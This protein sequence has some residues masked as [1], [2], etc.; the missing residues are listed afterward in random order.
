MVRGGGLRGRNLH[1]KHA[2]AAAV[3]VRQ[4]SAERGVAGIVLLG[5]LTRRFADEHS[6][7]DIVVVTDRQDGALKRRIE[8]LGRSM[9]GRTGLDI[10]L[11]VHSVRGFGG[12]EPTDWRR[13]E[14]RSA[15]IVLDR[16]GVVGKLVSRLVTVPDDFWVDRVVKDWTYLQWYACPP[17]GGSSIAESW[18][19]RGDLA[20][21]HYCMNYA[22]EILLELVYALNREF[23]PAP[24]WRVYSLH[25][26]GWRPK[27]LDGILRE[28]LSAGDISERELA[29]RIVALSKLR[30]Q[31][32]RKVLSVTGM[33]KQGLL[34]HFVKR[35]VYENR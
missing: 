33:S 26:L 12:L 9:G 29:R 27:G 11:E 3:L 34:E 24:K 18:L 28:M 15:E 32:D 7:V 31:L 19:D 30:G 22:L 10:D 35:A 8:G 1:R 14:Y 6:D 20:S 2:G 21:A 13:W 5:G 25:E 23:V 17:E 16:G 4:I